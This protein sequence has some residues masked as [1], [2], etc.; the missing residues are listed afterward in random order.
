M[1]IVLTVGSFDLLHFGH[2]YLLEECAKLGKV[3]VGLNTDEFIERYK[4]KKPVMKYFERESMLLAQQ[5]VY[6][7]HENTGCE[8][9]TVLVD[10]V[11][12]NYIVVGSD[13]LNK[14]YLKQT[15]LTTDY[16]EEME[17]SLVFV[18]RHFSISSTEIKE[19][20]KNET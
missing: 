2:L 9:M 5:S 11:C 13:W 8:D 18:P 3:I 20:I 17:I 19:R 12:P 15:G 10:E 14:D 4:G 6:E 1:P 16:L 7:V